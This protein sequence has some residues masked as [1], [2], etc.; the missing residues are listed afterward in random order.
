M[1]KNDY[2]EVCYIN[3]FSSLLEQVKN[4]AS[5]Y[6]EPTVNERQ[7]RFLF[8]RSSLILLRPVTD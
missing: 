1:K 5:S 8:L 4:N 2:N 6:N 3:V 7:P